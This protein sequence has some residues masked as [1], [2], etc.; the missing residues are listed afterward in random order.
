V[1]YVPGAD[2]KKFAE[3]QGKNY[4]SEWF[5]DVGFTTISANVAKKPFDDARIPKALRLLVDHQEALNAWA[6]TWFG[7]GYLS[8]AFPSALAD[9]DLTPQ[10]YAGYLPFKSPKDEA[11]RE[12]LSLLS[13]AGYTRDNPFRFELTSYSAPDWATSYIQLLQDQFR[14]LSQNV[15]Q[16]ATVKTYDAPTLATVL[17]KGE[18]DYAMYNQ[19]PSPATE[20]DAWFQNYYRTNGALNYGKWSDRALDNLIDKQI[21]IFDE[22]KRKAAIKEIMVYLVQNSPYIGWNGRYSLNASQLKVKNWAPESN[23]A[24]WGYAYEDVWLDV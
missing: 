8:M 22:P 17:A 4:T 16:I 9:W 24:I 21:E 20:P 15:A 11:A 3:E 5:N 14:K 19:S 12:A 10:E 18:Y 13:A 2:S 6:A 23:S 1:S 7:R